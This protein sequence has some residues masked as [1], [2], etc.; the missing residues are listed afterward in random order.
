MTIHETLKNSIPEEAEAG[1]LVPLVS[2][3]ATT[4]SHNLPLPQYLVFEYVERNLLEVL[5]EH[6]RGLDLEQVSAGVKQLALVVMVGRFLMLLPCPRPGSGP[7]V[8]TPA[9]ESGCLVPQAQHCAS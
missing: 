6:P 4:Y 1:E 8:H 3:Q 5:E 9:G 7:T 2:D